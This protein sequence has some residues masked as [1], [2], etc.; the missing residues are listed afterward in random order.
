MT[1]LV[2][3]FTGKIVSPDT[4]MTGEMTLRGLVLP[5]S[6]MLFLFS[7]C[8]HR[9]TVLTAEKETNDK[10]VLPM[11]PYRLAELRVRSLLHIEQVF[12]GSSYLK[13]ILRTYKRFPHL[14][15]YVDK[16]S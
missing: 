2:S 6:V 16:M 10:I 12:D 5:V 11:F 4:A 9:Q 1:S 8:R 15:G 14:Y 13:G 7:V 3:L